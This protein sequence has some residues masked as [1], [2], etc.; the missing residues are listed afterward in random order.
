[1]HAQS[2]TARIQ[3]SYALQLSAQGCRALT[4]AMVRAASGHM[5]TAAMHGVWIPTLDAHALHDAAS[6][7]NKRGTIECRG[8]WLTFQI[9]LPHG[10]QAY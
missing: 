6:K 9:R 7:H 1:M 10:M 3:A 2:S 5:R 4:E 8:A